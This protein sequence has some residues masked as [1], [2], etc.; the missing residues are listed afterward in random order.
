MEKSAQDEYYKEMTKSLIKA[1]IRSGKLCNEKIQQAVIDS[2][3][4]LKLEHE[5]NIN[6]ISFDNEYTSPMKNKDVST[7]NDSVYYESDEH[8]DTISDSSKPVDASNEPI[9]DTHI[10]EGINN[11][12]FEIVSV[13]P[14]FIGVGIIGQGTTQGVINRITN[15]GSNIATDILTNSS[16]QLFKT[17]TF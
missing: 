9:T 13:D 15:I 3:E 11:L 14:D 16:K 6:N 12:S 8:A 7:I 4:E 10:F 1:N 2:R 17:N 5:R